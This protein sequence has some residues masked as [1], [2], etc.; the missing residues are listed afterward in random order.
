MRV[1]GIDPGNNGAACVLDSMSSGPPPLL[2]FH[3]H[4]TF[5]VTNWLHHQHVDAVWVED[6]HSLYQVTAKSNFGLG[7]S[8]GIA[9]SIAEVARKGIQPFRVTPKVWQKYIGV[10][11]KGK[12][13][14]NDV[15]NLAANLYPKANLYGPK[16]GLKDGRADALMIAHYG[17]HHL[18]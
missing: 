18:P 17:L 2:D 7:R 10:A 12:A 11:S 5:E 16:G 14:K 13:I 15:A 9:L 1:C 6:I 8:V 3:N 4:S